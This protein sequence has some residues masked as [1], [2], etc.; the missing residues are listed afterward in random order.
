[1]WQVFEERGISARG[2]KTEEMR[3][4]LGSH[5]DFKYEHRVILVEHVAEVP[6][7]AKSN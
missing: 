2:L 4:I 7:R 1:M 5:P 6:L 3:A